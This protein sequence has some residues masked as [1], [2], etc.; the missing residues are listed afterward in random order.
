MP[1]RISR[2][3][4]QVR[5][6]CGRSWPFSTYRQLDGPVTVDITDSI[7]RDNGGN[8]VNAV[9]PGANQSIVSIKNSVIAKNGVAG[10]QA[11]EANAAIL[12]Q[13][14]LFD[15]NIAG[16]ISVVGGAHI[17]T[18]G[19]NSIVGSAGSGFTGSAPLQ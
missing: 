17:S 9:S 6:Q 18:Y 7:I 3:N 5:D 2:P 11:N 19:N 15:Q 4:G 16:A 1:R 10:V 13:T 12:V 14:T 8:G